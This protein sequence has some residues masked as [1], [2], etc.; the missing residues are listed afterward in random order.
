MKNNGSATMMV[1]WKRKPTV[2]RPSKK[3]EKRSS[4]D[5]QRTEKRIDL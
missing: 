3:S 1:S 5:R 4:T 2:K